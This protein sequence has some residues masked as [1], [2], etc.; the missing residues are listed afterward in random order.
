MLPGTPLHPDSVP[1]APFEEVNDDPC[2]GKDCHICPLQYYPASRL[3]TLDEAKSSAATLAY[4]ICDNFNY[5]GAILEIHADYIVRRWRKMSQDKR[6]LFL[7]E[8]GELYP[9]TPAH[10]HLFNANTKILPDHAIKTTSREMSKAFKNLGGWSE[11]HIEFVMRCV[12]EA[13]HPVRNSI[14]ETMSQ[15]SWFLPYL[16]I[17]T[18]SQSPL[19]LLSLL[20]SRTKHHPHQWALFDKMNIV[21]AEHYQIMPSQYSPSCVTFH[22]EQ[23]GLLVAWDKE[24]A[25]REDMIGF[26]QGMFVLTAQS[27]MM[28]L[29]RSF[30]DGLLVA[31]QKQG[32]GDA[33][34]AD[35]DRGHGRGQDQQQ[36]AL[37]HE[38]IPTSDTP[39]SQDLSPPQPKWDQLVQNGFSTFGSHPVAAWSSYTNRHLMSPPR[40]DPIEIQQKI[41]AA[42]QDALDGL[43]ALQ[44]DPGSVQLAVK[45]LCSCLCFHYTDREK[46][47]DVIADEV[48]LLPMRRELFWR[49][50]LTECD[51]LM[52]AYE[53]LKKGD[54]VESRLRY[55]FS[56]LRLW[57]CA[58][59]H[60]A[61][62]IQAVQYSLPYQPGFEKN[63]DW[64]QTSQGKRKQPKIHARDFLNDDPLFWSL[65]CFC[66]DRFREF[67]CDPVVYLRAFDQQLHKATDKERRRVS[68]NLLVQVGDLAA[69]DEIRTA[70]KCTPGINRNAV[71]EMASIP[72]YQAECRARDD[73]GHTFNKFK[74]D[75]WNTEDFAV[76]AF[77]L[78]KTLVTQCPWPRGKPTAETAQRV[79]DARNALS[80]MWAQIRRACKKRIIKQGA[81]GSYSNECLEKWSLDLSHEYKNLM[82]KEQIDIEAAFQAR[83]GTKNPVKPA[84]E[85]AGGSRAVWPAEYPTVAQN[86]KK[87]VLKD[88]SNVKV[89]VKTQ[90]DASDRTKAQV[91]RKAR[92]SATQQPNMGRQVILVKQSSLPFLRQMFPFAD[93]FSSEKDE[94]MTGV[95]S[96]K[97]QHF[98]DVM[99][100]VGFDIS[101]GSGSAV[102]FEHS[103][104][105]GRIVFHQPHPQPVIDPMMLRF[106]GKR[107]SKWF[108]WDRDLFALKE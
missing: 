91:Q 35:R 14:H 3:L 75:V 52:E 92:E 99:L 107:L 26:T 63:F 83:T 56:M 57:D 80:G 18:L 43:W 39:A 87:S 38:E 20:H 33:T 4:G 47:W 53:A 96:W 48:I 27:R 25:H 58:S 21:G 45:E 106:M 84:H 31:I 93:S 89:K 40:A 103:S 81:C 79:A 70:I 49:Q 59:E 30:V 72:R 67:N 11:D 60:M 62:A 98:V 1:T 22:P 44:T 6:H 50:T 82:A 55:D 71:R 41:R 74:N 37:Q 10:V 76:A 32:K 100:D 16:D 12:L 46:E 29:L 5:L 23:Y 24:S 68:P 36:A 102:S 54:S 34:T 85:M 69:I 8:I 65:D 66:N 78:L 77:P 105:L 94:P 86:L 73:I 108:G 28:N 101:Q 104:G 61:M 17:E 15:D 90:G 13:M 51:S 19:P 2:C 64:K 7:E 95:R 88:I 42:Y 97:W 9:N